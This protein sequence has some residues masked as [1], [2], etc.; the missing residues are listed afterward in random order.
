MLSLNQL[1]I[2]HVR[3]DLTFWINAHKANAAGKV[4]VSLRITV[5]GKRAEI[6]TGIRCLPERWDKAAKRLKPTGRH[7]EASRQLNTVLDDLEAKARLLASDLRTSATAERP[8]TAAALRTA[9]LPPPPTPVQCAIQL[10]HA[11]T[12]LRKNEFTR[13]TYVTALNKLRLYVAP[14]TTLLLPTLT[15]DFVQHFTAWLN[16]QV[17]AAAGV[18]YL[19]QLRALYGASCPD[20]ANPFSAAPA[21]IPAPTI[22]RPRYVLSKEELTKL[23][24]LP[25]TGREAVAR[26]V[27]M[28]Q[29]YLHGSRVGVMMELTWEQVD[30]QRQRVKYK[31]EKN[32]PWHDV[33]I[34]PPMAAILAIYYQGPSS[35]GFVFPILPRSYYQE[36]PRRRY[37]LRKVGNTYVWRGLQRIA[38]MMELPGKLHSHTARHSLATHT[39]EK[40]G[41]YRL[42]QNFLGHSTLSMTEKYVRS[43]LPA[44]L[45]AGADS[46]YDDE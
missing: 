8:L 17:G 36:L 40:T 35:T 43:M 2:S 24:D 38:E 3:V 5:H 25:L 44:E 20:L 18:P 29:Y 27:Y 4:P 41:N 21:K 16:E 30:W 42:A 6:S 28:T 37:M 26:D 15:P 34:R 45:D 33:A 32:G 9:L 10:L 11:A 7:D 23:R 22:S 12:A 13:A 39:V 46:V 14:A 31:A 1:Q 19:T